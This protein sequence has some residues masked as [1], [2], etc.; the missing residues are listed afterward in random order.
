MD[1][2][3]FL[4]TFVYFNDFVPSNWNDVQ[5]VKGNIL[6]FMAVVLLRHVTGI[7]DGRD[8]G[9]LALITSVALTR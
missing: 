3:L 7:R 1:C 5:P 8:A 6:S 4:K 2:L 9:T